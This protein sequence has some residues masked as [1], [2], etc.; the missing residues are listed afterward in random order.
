MTHWLVRDCLLNATHL[1]PFVSQEL[2]VAYYIL[3]LKR[4]SSWV[5]DSEEARELIVDWESVLV[6]L[7]VLQLNVVVSD[8]EFYLMEVCEQ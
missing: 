2:N 3:R 1:K 5:F 4:M 7:E 6:R 8:L